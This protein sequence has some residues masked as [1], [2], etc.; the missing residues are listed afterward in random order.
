M[1]SSKRSPELRPKISHVTDTQ[2]AKVRQFRALRTVRSVKT[3]QETRPLRVFIADD[4]GAIRY[5]LR[6][7]LQ[8][9]TEIGADVVGEAGDGAGLPIALQQAQPD[10]LLID[11]GL[12]GIDL[13]SEQIVALRVLCPN[14]KI[15]ALSVRAEVEKMALDAGADAFVSK[16]DPPDHLIAALNQIQ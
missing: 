13:S 1:V 8:I 12:P 2:T 7:L 5:A 11:W 6:L 15:I 10:L 3:G 16:C 14:M 9:A 4:Q